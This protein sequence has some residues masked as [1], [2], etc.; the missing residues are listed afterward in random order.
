MRALPPVDA[1]VGVVR[2]LLVEHARR[3]T[4]QWAS[5]MWPCAS[6]STWLT[7]ASP[8][9]ARRRRSSSTGRVTVDGAVVTD[10]ARGVS[11]DGGDRGRR[12][13][14]RG[15]GTRV[16]YALHKPAGVVSTAADTHGRPTV[17]DLVPTGQR[18]YPVGRLD[19]D[20]TGLILLTNDGDLAYALTHPRFEVPRTY[21]A[22]VEG[23]PE[24]ARAARAARG[25]RARGRPHRAGPRAPARPARARADDPRGPQAPGA[26]DVR[27]G[28][29]PRGGRCGASPSARCAWATWP[30]GATAG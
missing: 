5:V 11:G 25:H 20:S 15:P 8:R 17:V 13:V 21:R 19:A 1:A 22:R 23:P 27:G 28:R 30:P 26:A 24:R 18:L 4:E 29:A 16:V 14:V 6:E 2:G 7:P 10:P 9:G 3:M 12:R